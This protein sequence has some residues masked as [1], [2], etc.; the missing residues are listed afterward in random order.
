[1]ILIYDEVVQIRCRI[2]SIRHIR[3][4]DLNIRIDRAI[5]DLVLIAE[6]SK[7]YFKKFSW[8]Q[9]FGIFSKFSRILLNSG[10]SSHWYDSVRSRWRRSTRRLSRSGWRSLLRFWWSRRFLIPRGWLSADWLWGR[11]WCPVGEPVWFMIV[12]DG[13][14]RNWATSS[15]IIF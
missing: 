14:L 4:I 6:F 8:S 15:K 12:C 3:L 11:I 9:N 2:R 5:C 10:L 13:K 1:M 7:S